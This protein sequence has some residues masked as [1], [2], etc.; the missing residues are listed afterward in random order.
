[1]N[2]AAIRLMGSAKGTYAGNRFW[3]ATPEN[4]RFTF[5]DL[6]RTPGA[7]FEPSVVAGNAHQ[8]GATVFAWHDGTQGGAWDALEAMAT[9][10]PSDAA[11]N[12]V[13][14]DCVSQVQSSLGLTAAWV[15]WP[16]PGTGSCLGGAGNAVTYL[17]ALEAELPPTSRL[18]L[19]LDA[20]GRM[21]PE[22]GADIGALQQP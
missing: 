4:T 1:V 8:P 7:A 2:Q 15:G 11:A 16:E 14:E 13:T 18:G 19:E 3:T 9:A 21:R 10:Q 12:L 17:R 6:S 22:V 5:F 20:W